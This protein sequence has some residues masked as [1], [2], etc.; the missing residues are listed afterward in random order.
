MLILCIY[1]YLKMSQTTPT[2][3]PKTND[4]KNP[5]PPLL[6]WTRQTHFLGKIIITEKPFIL[7]FLN[8]HP[9]HSIP[10]T[11]Y[12]ENKLEQKD[13]DTLQ[14]KSEIYFRN[15][16]L[17]DCD[18]DMKDFREYFQTVMKVHKELTYL[19]PVMIKTP[20]YQSF[21]KR[22]RLGQIIRPNTF[23]P[24]FNKIHINNVFKLFIRKKFLIISPHTQKIKDAIAKIPDDCK[25][26]NRLIM[27]HIDWVFVDYKSPNKHGRKHE[28]WKSEFE[29][30]KA[31][32]DPLEFEFAIPDC[33][34]YSYPLADYL[35]TEK[36]SRVFMFAPLYLSWFGLS[37]RNLAINANKP[38]PVRLPSTPAPTPPPSE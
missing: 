10:L 18:A 28:S 36:K 13:I 14:D 11:M 32:I 24:V 37:G 4:E 29:A 21:I 16:E 2:A 15:K 7:M 35:Y 9:S 6:I 12:H 17:L 30:M 34:G 5:D 20:N 22:Y 26:I 31:K 19:A 3:E 23:M 25:Q 1:I 8:L 33:E 38:E 27:K